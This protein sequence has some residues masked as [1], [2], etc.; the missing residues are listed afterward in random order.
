MKPASTL[1]LTLLLGVVL[2]GGSSAKAQ[3]SSNTLR[4]IDYAFFAG[5]KLAVRMIFK[6]ELVEPPGT[7]TT[8]YPSIRTV[9]DFASMHS[10]V[11]TTPIEVHQRDLWTLQVVQSGARTRVII[12]LLRPMIREMETTG[13][14]LMIT[15]TP[16]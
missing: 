13:K 16:P 15:L 11:S 12:H 14:E 8:Y 6:Q 4:S 1:L 2:S 10:A 7:F 3:E 5:G 9:L